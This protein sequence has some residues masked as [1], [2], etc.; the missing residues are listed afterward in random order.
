MNFFEHQDRAHRKTKLLVFYFSL[1][2]LLIIFSI[3]AIVYSAIYFFSDYYPDFRKLLYA[4]IWV[5]LS[6]S[7]LLVITLGSL[8]KMFMLRGG[9]LSVAQMVKARSINFHT[10]NFEEKRL[11]HIVEEMSI[12]SGVPIPKLFIMDNEPGINA[13]VAG[14]KPE[15]TVL[16]VTKGALEHLNRAELQGVIGHEFSHI[17]NSDMRI[18]IRL[19]G[20]LAGILVIGVMG[21]ILLR[22]AGL[23]SRGVQAR[24]NSK[25]NNG[26]GAAI[27]LLIGAG[28]MLV[29]Y[30]GLF[31]GRIIKAAI[32]RQRELLADSSSVQY[33][34]YPAGLVSAFKKMQKLQN[35]SVL[36]SEHVED[37]SHLCFGE[38]MSFAMLNKLFSTHPP[39][40]QRIRAIDPQGKYDIL[41]DTPLHEEK[42]QQNN[43]GKD[44]KIETLLEPLAYTLAAGILAQKEEIKNSIGNPNQSHIEYAKKIHSL[45]PDPLLAVARH[46]DQVEELYYAML[47]KR[48]PDIETLM[49]YIEK[50]LSFEKKEKFMEITNFL[51]PMPIEIL[52]PLFDISLPAFSE[53]T[54]ETKKEIFSQIEKFS[55]LIG[56]SPF[57]FA[58]LTILNK[59]I[60]KKKVAT[61]QPKYHNLELVEDEVCYLFSFLLDFSHTEEQTKTTLF[62]ET[63]LRLLSKSHKKPI[64]KQFDPLQFRKILEKLNALS[65][66]L[67]NKLLSS[68]VDLILNDEKIDFEEAELLRIISECLD[69]PMPPIF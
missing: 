35:S 48:F 69:S 61:D 11:I 34:R 36:V 18:N 57:Q 7:V 5:Y 67:K 41:P 56:P 13:F 2:V 53:N 62:N 6:G 22:S 64:I 8:F 52:L 54:K 45:I 40:E 65:P 9:G 49:P 14:V 26:G 42:K 29:G 16:V 4:P 58:L 32:S 59:R 46:K 51:T 43:D 33:T 24:R 17:F 37:I 47:V 20:I 21:E 27:L 68:C 15:D 12:A 25:S 3:N 31:M 19:M 39:L 10:N 50:N 44:S 23:S 66:E 1:A 60:E 55:Q 38:A 63:I 30:I 28:V